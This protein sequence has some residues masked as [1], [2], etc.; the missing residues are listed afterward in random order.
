MQL[1]SRLIRSIA[2]QL[3]RN[4][5]FVLVQRQWQV[6]SASWDWLPFVIRYICSSSFAQFQCNANISFLHQGGGFVGRH[7]QWEVQSWLICPCEF[8]W[9]LEALAA[10]FFWDVTQ[11]SG[12]DV[13]CPGFGNDGS[14]DPSVPL[15]HLWTGKQFEI[16]AHDVH[17]G[18][19]TWLTDLCILYPPACSQYFPS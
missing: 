1:H 4:S 18:T 19:Q 17:C 11:T 3:E 13:C 16:W 5:I 10:L 8:Q 14:G 6:S 12:R 15:F 9:T 7:D 2:V